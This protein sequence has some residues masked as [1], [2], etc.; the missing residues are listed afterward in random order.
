VQGATVTPAIV[1]GLAKNNC[2]GISNVGR[3]FVLDFGCLAHYCLCRS[4]LLVRIRH[5][6][7]EELYNRHVAAVFRFAM[8][9]VGRRDIAEDL[10]S[11][12]FM[13]LL[14]NLATVDAG[15]LPAW[16]LTVVRNRAIDFWRKESRER[17]HLSTLPVDP[18][19]PEELTIDMDLLRSKA[20]KPIHRACLVLR[21]VHGMT[22]AEVAA[23]TELSTG[24]VKGHLQYARHLLRKETLKDV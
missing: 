14:R 7:F 16:L 1:V 3:F 5:E 9:S 2:I 20:L 11:D 21:Y 12:A 8:R 22:L 15:Q 17:Q 23:R 10:T 18:A 24:Q 19:A 6:G 13:A 4:G